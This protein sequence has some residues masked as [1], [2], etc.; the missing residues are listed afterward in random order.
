MDEIIDYSEMANDEEWG[1]SIE[2]EKLPLDNSAEII[3]N[4]IN[5]ELA[6]HQED[7]ANKNDLTEQ[8]EPQNSE[9]K[10]EKTEDAPQQ[11]DTQE[12]IIEIP[13]PDGTVEKISEDELKKSYFRQSD[14][15]RKTQELAQIRQQ[16]EA[17]FIDRT[18]ALI[19]K[20]NPLTQLEQQR[21]NL[22]NQ[23][24][25][26]REIGDNETFTIKRLD[27]MELDKYASSVQ[28]E[29]NLLMQAK[30][31]NDNQITSQNLEMEREKLFKAIPELNNPEKAK[32]FS[33]LTYEALSKVGY[34]NEDMQKMDKGVDARQAQLAYYAGLYLKMQNNAPQ[35][36]KNIA[37]KIVTP[38][39]SVARN[40]SK[41]NKIAELQR[42]AEQGDDNAYGELLKIQ[43][44]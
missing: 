25:E 21:Q 27:L 32:E 19:N 23:A 11:I 42:L 10:T 29:I 7:N 44:S 3:N 24:N 17:D 13:L 9:V 18:T 33:Q 20:Y 1:A 4:D 40:D 28:E 43:Y 5:S 38:K 37:D 31:F 2:V 30:Q 16:Q 6:E 14:Y 12:R 8:S 22:I 15:T 34:S 35:M 39:P 36:A 26:A 41:Q